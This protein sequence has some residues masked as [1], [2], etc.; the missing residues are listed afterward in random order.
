[1]PVSLSL[2]Q[3][4]RVVLSAAGTSYSSDEPKEKASDQKVRSLCLCGL[5]FSFYDT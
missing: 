5:S 4:E 2:L 1:M 3:I